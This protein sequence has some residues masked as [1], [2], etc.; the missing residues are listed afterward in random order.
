MSGNGDLMQRAQG[1]APARGRDPVAEVGSLLKRMG[2]E[3]MAALP[4]T[5]RLTPE[6]LARIAI[7]T[8]RTTPALMR[9]SVPSLLGA[10]VQ[11]AQL[12]LEPDP[13]LGLAYLVPY[14]QDAQLIIGYR[15]LIHLARRSG[16]VASVEA[17][18]VYDRDEFTCRYGADGTLSHTPCLQF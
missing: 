11:C 17:H 3:I 16:E 6:R 1:Q 14:G 10:L 7:T 18:V 9:C 12:G 13:R 5:A 2:P 15:G 4:V 8:L